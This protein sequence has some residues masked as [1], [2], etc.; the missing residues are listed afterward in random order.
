MANLERL[1][2]LK[3]NEENMK[4]FF[5]SLVHQLQ[6]TILRYSDSNNVIPRPKWDR[7]R[8]ELRSIVTQAFIGP[9]HQYSLYTIANRQMK[10]PSPFLNALWPAFSGM[11]S[12]GALEQQHLMVQKLKDHPEIM[13]VLG[14]TAVKRPAVIRE[15]EI[16]PQVEYDPLHFF[17]DPKG[18]NLSDHVWQTAVETRSKL[19][20]MVAD[21]IKLGRS[22]RELSKDVEVY[23]TPGEVLKRTGKPYG[24]DGSFSAMRLARTEVSS[25]HTLASHAAAL[26]NPFVQE[27]NV[28][29]SSSHTV[30]DECDDEADGGPY[31]KNDTSH[32]PVF[33]PHCMC[34]VRWVTTEDTNSVISQL[35]ALLSG[36]G[37]EVDN[38]EANPEED[39]AS[40]IA[41]LFT[42]KIL[43]WLLGG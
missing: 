9:T 13:E 21:G 38:V 18:Y 12:L 36:D 33:H 35:Q 14:H 22:A 11:V 25:A 20:A 6:G 28:V 16:R 8:Q 4:T 2:L 19:D 15:T 29:L 24:T 23:L 41:D 3:L 31:D 39:L 5:T 7:L 43:D 40:L 34:T 27:Y 37:G 26:K 42:G 1:R 17:V 10:T 32:L 30:P